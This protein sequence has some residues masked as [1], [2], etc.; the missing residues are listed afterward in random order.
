MF[1]E[2]RPVTGEKFTKYCGWAATLIDSLDTLHIMGLQKE[3]EE[4][5]AALAGVDFNHPY[6]TCG[7][8]V[9]ETTIRH[10]GGLLAAFDLDGGKNEILRRKLEEAGEM[11]FAEFGTANRLPCGGF[12]W[13]LYG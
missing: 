12:T 7:V 11:L 10:L 8:N 13:P 5:V 9:F 6:E 2:L 4:A 1:D 3:W